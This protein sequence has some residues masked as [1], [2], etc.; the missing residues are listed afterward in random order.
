MLGPTGT[1]QILATQ[2]GI[3]PLAVVAEGGEGNPPS[4]PSS[5]SSSALLWLRAGRGA[6]GSPPSPAAYPPPPPPAWH[7]ALP[8]SNPA[9]AAPGR[10]KGRK[11][12]QLGGPGKGRDDFLHAG[13][14]G[15]VA[16]HSMQHGTV[17]STVG[18]AI[19]QGVRHGSVQGVQQLAQGSEAEHPRRCLLEPV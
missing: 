10:D 2:A 13:A 1:G 5:S 11:S 9:T 6:P 14:E 3:L 19:R 17:C 15:C 7:P 8:C 4:S 16:W 12:L 18:C